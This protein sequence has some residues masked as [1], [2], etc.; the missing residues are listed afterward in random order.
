MENKLK[1]SKYR[2]LVKF[3]NGIEIKADSMSYILYIPSPRNYSYYPTLDSL[4]SEL[5]TLRIKELA[6]RDSRKTISSL[7]DAI[8]Q[9]QKEIESTLAE[10][11]TIKIPEQ[12]RL[13]LHG[14]VV[15]NKN[16]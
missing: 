16:G 12:S 2:T 6:S 10:L 3:K 14:G 8:S 7:S 9:A 11:T 13:D 15:D 1:H 4:F 5:L